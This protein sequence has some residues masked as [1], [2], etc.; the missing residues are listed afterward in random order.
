MEILKQ[1]DPF[2][3]YRPNLFPR[4]TATARFLGAF[5]TQH[6]EIPVRGAEAFLEAEMDAEEHMEEHWGRTMDWVEHKVVDLRNPVPE[7]T[8]DILDYSTLEP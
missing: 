3:G 7:E 6:H 1:K 5:V 8:Q 2:E 4:L